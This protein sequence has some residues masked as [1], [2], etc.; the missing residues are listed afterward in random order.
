MGRVIR[1]ADQTTS[2]GK[3]RPSPVPTRPGLRNIPVRDAAAHLLLVTQD[4]G[5]RKHA[6]NLYTF[7]LCLMVL[8]VLLGLTIAA[9][10]IPALAG[11]V[12]ALLAG[13]AAVLAAFRLVR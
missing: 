2:E 8:I 1:L 3:R 7:L 12:L 5:I 10:V 4:L 11:T 13:W 6:M 9:V